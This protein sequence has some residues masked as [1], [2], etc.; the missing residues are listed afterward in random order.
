MVQRLIGSLKLYSPLWSYRV[1]YKTMIRTTPFNLVYGLDAILPLEF[2]VPTLR[3]AKELE[4]NGHELSNQLEE[5]ERLDESRLVV[6]A[7]MYAL[8]RRQKQLHDHRKL[9]K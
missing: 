9:T 6:V 2:L 3:V 1:T 7:G 8:K 4:W 5:L